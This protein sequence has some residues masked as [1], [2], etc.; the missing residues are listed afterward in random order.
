MSIINILNIGKVNCILLAWLSVWL[1]SATQ[2]RNG[3]K[4]RKKRKQA[5]T[6][7]NDLQLYLTYLELFCPPL[8]LIGMFCVAA[9]PLP[10]TL[11]AAF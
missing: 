6:L 4:N 9:L 5:G 3:I 2:N 7:L 8:P 11:P 1:E 10:A